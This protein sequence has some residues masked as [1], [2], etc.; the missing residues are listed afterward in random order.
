MVEVVIEAAVVEVAV[1]AAAVAD[2][3][4]VVFV[5]LHFLFSVAQNFADFVFVDFEYFVQYLQRLRFCAAELLAKM[6]GIVFDL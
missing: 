2:Y 1:V 3:D 6:L 5:V 4:A